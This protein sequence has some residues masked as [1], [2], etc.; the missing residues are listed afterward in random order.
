M[1][2]CPECACNN[3]EWELEC[4]C[5]GWSEEQEDDDF[6]DDIDESIDS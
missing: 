5:C 1:W 2:Q 3:N 4:A 6:E